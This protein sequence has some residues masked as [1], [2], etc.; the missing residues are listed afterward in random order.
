MTTLMISEN[1]APDKSRGMSVAVEAV[2]SSRALTERS[3]SGVAEIDK[4]S[5]IPYLPHILAMPGPIE[6]IGT[7]YSRLNRQNF[8]SGL[9]RTDLIIVAPDQDIAECAIDPIDYAIWTTLLRKPSYDRDRHDQ[10][11]DLSALAA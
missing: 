9:S 11:L 2:I 8:R 7:F 5:V 4:G 6:E 3:P 1:C 10:G